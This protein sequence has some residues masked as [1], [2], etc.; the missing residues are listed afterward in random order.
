[1]RNIARE[2]EDG[3]GG[4]TSVACFLLASVNRAFGFAS[5]GDD[6]FSSSVPFSDISNS[7]RDLA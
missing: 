2:Q 5:H 7:F 6:D 3:F 4:S 1:M